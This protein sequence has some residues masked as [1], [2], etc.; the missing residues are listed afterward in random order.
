MPTSNIEWTVTEDVLYVAQTLVFA[1]N[2]F[3][4]FNDIICTELPTPL[5]SVLL[6]LIEPI[7]VVLLITFIYNFEQLKLMVTDMGMLCI[8]LNLLQL[9]YTSPSTN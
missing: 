5:F 8:H 7:V 6:S 3:S 9:H 2:I 1:T 4:I